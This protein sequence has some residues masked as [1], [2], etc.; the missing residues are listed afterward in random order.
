MALPLTRSG[1]GP[2]SEPCS[3]TLEQVARAALQLQLGVEVRDEVQRQQLHQH[4]EADVAFDAEPGGGRVELAHRA[5][6]CMV[7]EVMAK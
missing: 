1:R 4:V 3:P 2:S 7:L 5:P 6:N